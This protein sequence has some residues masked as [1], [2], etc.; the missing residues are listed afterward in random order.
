VPLD[1]GVVLLEAAG[2]QGEADAIASE[3][4]TLLRSGVP[5]DEILVVLPTAEAARGALE[6]ALAAL[7][8]PYA[9]DA[10]V[11]LGRTAF[12]H[13]LLALCR[14]AWL[15]GDRDALFAW[16]RS[17]AGGLRRSTVDAWEGRIRGRGRHRGEESYALLREL[18]GQAVEAVETL[19]AA[20][21]PLDGLRLVLDRA[22]PAAFGLG[23]RVRE[24]GEAAVQ[25]R[26][27]R[28]VDRALE[29]LAGL[30]QPP[31][32]HEL[33]RALEGLTVRVGD[34]RRSGRVRVVSLRRARTHAAE[35][36]IVAGLEEGRLPG[37]GRTDAFV[38]DDVRGLLAE[39]GL[40]LRR[41]DA[42]AR[43]RYLFYTA[44]T[45]ARR[46]LVL[47]RQ[48]VGDDGTPR[49]PSPFWEEVRRVLGDGCPLPVRRGLAE[50][51]YPLE[52]APS[53]RERMRSVAAL[54]GREPLL[55]RRLARGLAPG[56]ERRLDRA[57]RALSRPTRLSDR[58]LVEVL[59]ARDRF[60]VTDLEVFAECS[61]RWFVERVLDP[62]DID[63]EVDAR[64][65]GSVAHTTLQRF[66][67]RLPARIGKDVL[68][69]GDL[70]R[71]VPLLH[72]AIAESMAGQ[73]LP[74]D[75]LEMR[76]LGRT[77]ERDLEAFLR[78]EI[79][80]DH[81]LVPRDLEVSFG[82]E[83]S[84]PHLQRG[85]VIDDFAVSGR[86]DRVDRDPLAAR[87]LVHDYKY[88]RRAESAVQIERERKLQLPL[89]ILALRDLLGLEPVG[90]LYR[91]LRGGQA[92]GIVR[93]EAREDGAAGFADKDY[94]DEDAFWGAIE[95]ARDDA[96][97]SVRRIRRGDIRHDPRQGSC[98]SWCDAWP[99]CRVARG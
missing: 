32:E 86:I 20:E 4:A 13:A 81:R 78:S 43:E 31:D 69:A 84:A 52:S 29:G 95:R 30:A 97:G 62:R 56:A 76:E 65:R 85:L 36:V 22:A 57:C 59:A 7:D 37:R 89:Y 91:P 92:R 21:R 98:P 77:L 88:S 40:E 66:F 96:R 42:L 24:E 2:A 23:A 80:L 60:R 17:P 15:G 16:L 55:G 14:F 58:T 73:S 99:I 11:P 10:R 72:E 54:A 50:T 94:L 33:V 63:R 45:R 47:L 74:P 12:G 87:G 83:R 49:E 44:V 25:I 61:Q 68:E 93:A 48:A 41:A 38:P 27:W 1:G 9:L 8:V 64:M 70:D 35:V 26:A 46:T 18:T 71:A 5:A 28:A 82:N 3:V 6:R 67:S 19:R 90:G 75:S 34:D 79:A 39:H 51:T 53:A